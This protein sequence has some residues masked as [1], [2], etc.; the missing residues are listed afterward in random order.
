[1]RRVLIVSR[2]NRYGLSADALILKAALERLGLAAS[3]ATP[4]S[5]PLWDR[6]RRK[7]TADLVLHLER[8]FRSWTSAGALNAAVPNQERYPRSHI[9]KL[10]RVDMVWAKTRHAEAIFSALGCATRHIGFTSPDRG[11]RGVAKRWDRFL[12]V[13]GGSTLKGTAG[14]V[15]LWERHPEWPELVIVQKADNAPKVNLAN[16]RVVSRYLPDH[17][18]RRL[19]NECGVHLCTSSAEGWGHY[20]LEGMSCASLV[21]TTDAPPMN[22]HIRPGTGILIPY[23]GTEPRHLGTNF[24]FDSGKLEAAIAQ[25]VRM[26]DDAKAAI[27]RNAALRFAEIDRAFP[28]SLET[29]LEAIARR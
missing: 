17:E 12:H 3:I 14:I 18:L 20:I 19:Q 4:R 16:V 11:E 13:A 9:G 28:A 6:L 8:I 21:V 29:A 15:A 2:N 23:S 26:P 1:M 7:Q 5:R 10:R 22:E 25:L 24:F 27:G